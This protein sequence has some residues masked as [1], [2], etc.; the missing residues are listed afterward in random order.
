[1]REDAVSEADS[2][3]NGPR[4][5]TERIAITQLLRLA[6]AAAILAYLFRAVPGAQVFSIFHRAEF[7]WLIMGFLLSLLV[8]VVSAMR[9]KI[10]T[11]AHSLGLTTLDV[12]EINLVTRFYGLFLP[13]GSVTATAVRVF[14]LVQVRP[15]YAGAITAVVFDR[16]VAT[17]VMCGI[18]IVFWLLAWTPGQLG[19]LI[20]MAFALVWLVAPF[21]WICARPSDPVTL[22]NARPRF[23]G[24]WFRSISKAIAELQRIPSRSIIGIVGWSVLANLI[25]IAEYFAFAQSIDM[26]IEWFALGWIRSAM[27]VA[28]LIPVS[29]SGLGLREGAALLV[30]PVYGVGPDVAL[31]YSLLV[32]AVS[33]VA[34]GLFGGLLELRQVLRAPRV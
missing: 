18:G 1:M 20:M 28:S 14:K 6:V 26:G 3:N 33:N 24:G 4:L 23:L 27:L 32:F 2:A 25:G 8:Q 34:V 19:W 30:L 5:Q 13:G 21:V 22:C 15:H 9:L 11:D 17:L 10:V 29:L 7:S 12:F 16:L 31:A